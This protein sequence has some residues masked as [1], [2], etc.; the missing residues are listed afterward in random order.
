[1]PVARFKAMVAGKFM[2][3]K[4]AGPSFCLADEVMGIVDYRINA[5]AW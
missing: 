2:A 4:K 5:R 3:V 1:M